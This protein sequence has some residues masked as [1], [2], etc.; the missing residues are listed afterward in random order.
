[1]S[2]LTSRL[3]LCMSMF[4]GVQGQSLGQMRVQCCLERVLDALRG[5]TLLF[6]VLLHP[7]SNDAYARVP[8]VNTSFQVLRSSHM[9]VRDVQYS[10]LPY[11][12]VPQ[13]RIC[14]A[15]SWEYP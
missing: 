15:P 13:P 5:L 14:L 12:R 3:T 1:M 6:A 4:S 2:R 8:R 10:F 9:Y 7:Y 11:A